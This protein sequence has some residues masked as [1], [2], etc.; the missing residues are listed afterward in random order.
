MQAQHHLE[1]L[2]LLAADGLPESVSIKVTERP[3]LT[4]SSLLD[5]SGLLPCDG[6][7]AQSGDGR[8]D[9]VPFSDPLPRLRRDS[10]EACCL[11]YAANSGNCFRRRQRLAQQRLSESSACST[12]T[13]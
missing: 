1:L 12:G 10:R 2:L 5:H 9:R 11:H 13:G 7:L 3:V 8:I 6:F 4:R